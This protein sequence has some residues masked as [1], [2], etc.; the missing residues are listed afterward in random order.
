MMDQTPITCDLVDQGELDRRYV[1][2]RLAEAEAAAFEEHFFGCDR[3]WQLVKGGTGVRAALRPERARLVGSRARW[4]PLA[5]AAAIGI[6]ALGIWRFAGPGQTTEPDGIR[7]TGDSLAVR[8]GFSA[9]AWHLAWPA[10]A[11][12]TSYRVRLSAPDGRLLYSRETGDTTLDVAADS[13][14]PAGEY[15]LLY[16]DVQ[17]FDELRQPLARSP[18]IPL[19]SS[20]TSP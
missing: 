1:E 11:Q 20:A 2:G 15:P 5:F 4:K 14:P 6:V 3:C 16:L 7:G 10:F 8:S 18:L 9:G 12:A 17:A 13:L 19:S